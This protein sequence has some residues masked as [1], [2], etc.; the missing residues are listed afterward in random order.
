MSPDKSCKNAVSG[1][2][3]NCL[4]K[5]QKPVST[6]TGSNA[7]ASARLPEKVIYSLVK[8]IGLRSIKK[9]PSLWNPFGREVNVFDGTTITLQATKAN[10]IIY[11]KHSNGK[12]IGL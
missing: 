4:V 7:K 12:Q 9:A 5:G 2:A 11:S 1:L 8:S 6:S 3:I 10:S